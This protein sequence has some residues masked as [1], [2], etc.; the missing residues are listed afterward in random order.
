MVKRIDFLLFMERKRQLLSS[1]SHVT[2]VM[3]MS[4]ARL[5]NPLR[6]HNILE[7]DGLSDIMKKGLAFQVLQKVRSSPA[8]WKNERINVMAMVRQLG[9]STLFVT[10]SAAEAK[11]PEL[12]VILKIV[13]DNE[14]LTKNEVNE[15]SREEKARLIQSDSITCARY[16]NRRMRILKNT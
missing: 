4:K 8:Y 14:V 15:L 5:K 9:I 16:F 10:L 13:L 1:A 2:T 3:R 7:N 12:L 6:V 11:W